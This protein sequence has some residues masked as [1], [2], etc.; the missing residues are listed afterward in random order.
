V[1]ATFAPSGAPVH[2]LL[3]WLDDRYVYVE[4]PSKT[5][6]PYIDKF[7]LCEAGLS[8]AL[9]LLRIRYDE[10][11]SSMKN[12]VVPP[13]EPSMKNGK[14]PIQTSKQRDQALAVLRKMGMV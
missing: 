12:Y 4:I 10:L 7:P 9:N 6:S 1:S 11:P 2:A 3:C 13:I 5:G 8:K 14:A